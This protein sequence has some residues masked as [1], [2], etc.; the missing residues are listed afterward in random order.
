MKSHRITNRSHFILFSSLI[1]IFTKKMMELINFT[2]SQ[3]TDSKFQENK[4]VEGRGSI[5]TVPGEQ[6]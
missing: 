5:V 1:P 2:A 4:G 6:Q 3:R